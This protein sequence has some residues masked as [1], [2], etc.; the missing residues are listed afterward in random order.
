M[1]QKLF[2]ICIIIIV[3]T[4]VLFGVGMIVLRYQVEGETNLPFEI[5]K[6]SIISSVDGKDETDDANKWNISV[7]QNNDIYIYI[8]KNNDYNKTEIIDSI[9]IDNIRINKN[10]EKGVT[11]IYKPTEKGSVSAILQ[12]TLPFLHYEVL[13]MSRTFI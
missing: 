11:N 6:I 4:A 12:I 1:K 10:T 13:P 2:Q 8:D 7:N 9:I 3:V 5:T